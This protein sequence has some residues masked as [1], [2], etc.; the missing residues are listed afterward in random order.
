MTLRNSILR[1]Y[2]VHHVKE[3]PRFAHIA[4]SD[5][6]FTLSQLKFGSSKQPHHHSTKHNLYQI[7]RSVELDAFAIKTMDPDHLRVTRSQH[8]SVPL[9]ALNAATTPVRDA[10]I[11]PPLAAVHQSGTS[12]ASSIGVTSAAPVQTPRTPP[13]GVQMQPIEESV[14]SLSQYGASAVA[15]FERPPVVGGGVVAAAISK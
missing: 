2:K 8:A 10:E 3:R 15:G 11:P 9:S 14:A 13:R 4:Y 12:P 6:Y 7:A 1:K 5:F